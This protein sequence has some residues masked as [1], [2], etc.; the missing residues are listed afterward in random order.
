MKEAANTR[1][2]ALL[3]KG[4]QKRENKLMELEE[5]HFLLQANMGRSGGCAIRYAFHWEHC[6]HQTDDSQLQ[7]GKKRKE[8]DVSE[9]DFI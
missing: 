2:N 9:G 7:R 1:R 8:E 6:N 4:Q 5:L 3:E